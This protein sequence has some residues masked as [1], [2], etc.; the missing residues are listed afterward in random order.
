MSKVG[1]TKNLHVGV[2]SEAKNQFGKAGF[3]FLAEWADSRIEPRKF[4]LKLFLPFWRV[5]QK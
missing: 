4:V 2:Q 5:G 3:T 1:E